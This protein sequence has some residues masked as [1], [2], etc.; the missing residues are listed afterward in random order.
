MTVMLGVNEKNTN[1]EEGVTKKGMISFKWLLLPSH[2]KYLWRM[3]MMMIQMLLFPKVKRVNEGKKNDLEEEWMDEKEQNQRCSS[4]PRNERRRISSWHREHQT[5][6]HNFLS[7]HQETTHLFAPDFLLLSS[8]SFSCN[9]FWFTSY[10]THTQRVENINQIILV[11][12][13]VTWYPPLSIH[14]NFHGFRN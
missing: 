11:L 9:I 14:A 5:T 3:T 6:R 10:S 2:L 13:T 12:M 7:Y 4:H 8:P 1:T